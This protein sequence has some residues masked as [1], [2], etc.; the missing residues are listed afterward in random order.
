MR[1]NTAELG[2]ACFIEASSVAL[3]ESERNKMGK[4]KT[5]KELMEASKK[6]RERQN[7]ALEGDGDATLLSLN[8]LL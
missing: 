1:Q 7:S 3:R 6:M 8:C 5:P 4:K 2:I